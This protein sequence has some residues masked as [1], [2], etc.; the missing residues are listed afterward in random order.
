MS[1]L[2]KSYPLCCRVAERLRVHGGLRTIGRHQIDPPGRRP[3]LHGRPPRSLPRPC[4]RGPRAHRHPAQ[5]EPPRGRDGQPHLDPAGPGRA[6][7]TR[8]AVGPLR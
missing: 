5:A 1:P 2:I 8:Q 7:D 4:V 3:P 6:V